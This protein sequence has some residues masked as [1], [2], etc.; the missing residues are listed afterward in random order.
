MLISCKSASRH[1]KSMEEAV[2]KECRAICRGGVHEVRSDATATVGSFAE[3]VNV[4]ICR[5]DFLF[6]FLIERNRC[7]KTLVIMGQASI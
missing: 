1:Y 5:L 7:L 2:A 4:Q 3:T 6:F